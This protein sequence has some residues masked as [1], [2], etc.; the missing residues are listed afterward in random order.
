MHICGDLHAHVYIYICVCVS[1]FG[2]FFLS[3][4]GLPLNGGCPQ[5][6]HGL[7]L[8]DSLH[9]LV[10]VERTLARRHLSPFGRSFVFLVCWNPARLWQLNARNLSQWRKTS[11]ASVP[12]N[13]LLRPSFFF[14]LLLL[15]LWLA[16]CSSYLVF[17]WA[18]PSF[19]CFPSDWMPQWI[20]VHTDPSTYLRFSFLAALA[21]WRTHL[22]P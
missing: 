14:H 15:Y 21:S 19:A 11:S 10:C 12:I 13:H 8:S 5:K 22:T 7:W 6:G 3:D 1:A 20:L 16:Y 2:V 9:I 18:V 17:L 4:G